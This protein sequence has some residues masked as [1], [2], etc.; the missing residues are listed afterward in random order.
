MKMTRT[1]HHHIMHHASALSSFIIIILLSLYTSCIES[2]IVHQ[3]TI[4]KDATGKGTL[5][6]SPNPLNI[7]VVSDCIQHCTALQ[8]SC[9]CFSLSTHLTYY[10]CDYTDAVQ[11]TTSLLTKYHTSVH[12]TQ[13][14]CIYHASS[15]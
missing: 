8:S 12:C 3:V 14:I 10:H 15:G 7:S 1:Y 4:P 6:F 13:L 2:Q 9:S 5:A 11:S